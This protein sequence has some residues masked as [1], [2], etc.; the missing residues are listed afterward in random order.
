MCA[1]SLQEATFHR[2][3][4]LLK[5]SSNTGC[6]F[7]NCWIRHFC[8]CVTL[9]WLSY[10]TWGKYKVSVGLQYLWPGLFTL[11]TGSLTAPRTVHTPCLGIV[12][13][14]KKGCSCFVYD[15]ETKIKNV[16]EDQIQFILNLNLRLRSA[17]NRHL[18][19]CCE[20]L[21]KEQAERNDCHQ[22][23]NCPKRTW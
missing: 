18:P 10:E 16:F 11:S 12:N 6:W 4:E 5:A 2:H 23:T 1:Q 13:T 7:C 14:E 8:C 15:S 17:W 9:L 21:M 19:I 20:P 22:K 3:R